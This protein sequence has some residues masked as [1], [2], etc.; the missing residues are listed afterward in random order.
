MLNF[1]DFYGISLKKQFKHQLD[2]PHQRDLA[3]KATPTYEVTES[4]HYREGTT[5]KSD[6]SGMVG[7]VY[8]SGTP[9]KHNFS[10]GY[11]GG[12]KAR[13]YFLA[14]QA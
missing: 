8:S 14:A 9:T 11:A 7:P 1:L 13:R 6:L 2:K 4:H 10:D 12:P 5:H 3:R